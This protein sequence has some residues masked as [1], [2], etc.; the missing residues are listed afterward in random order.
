MNF[1]R[2]HIP[3][4]TESSHILTDLLKKGNAWKWTEI[5]E[6]KLNDLKRKLSAM[7]LLGVPNSVGEMVIVTDSSDYGGG[8]SIFQ[9]QLLPSEILQK[10]GKRCEKKN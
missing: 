10:V 4:F 6:N 5:E 1:F 7:T 9:W 8:A 2:R 3:R